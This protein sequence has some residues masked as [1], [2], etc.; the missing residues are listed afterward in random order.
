MYKIL[1]KIR[2]NK[3]GIETD[4]DWLSPTPKKEKNLY[5]DLNWSLKRASPEVNH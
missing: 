1:V 4:V 2:N 3:I 5:Q